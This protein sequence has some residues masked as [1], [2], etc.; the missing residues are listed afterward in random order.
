MNIHYIDSTR[1][2]KSTGSSCAQSGWT[3][4]SFPAVS[5]TA[6][7][8]ARSRPFRL[9][10]EIRHSLPRHLPRH[11]GRCHRSRS[12]IW[13]VSTM[14]MSTEFNR[15]HAA[16]GRRTDY[17]V[18][19]PQAATSKERSE[20]SN[21]GGT[22]RLGRAGHQTLV[23]GFPGRQ[24]ATAPRRS[25]ERH[26]HR[27]EV[28]NHYRDQ[29]RQGRACVSRACPS[30]IWSRWSS[31][32]ITRGSWQASSTPNS[33]PTRVTAIRCSRALSAPRA[34]YHETA[35]PEVREA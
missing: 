29:S 13:P 18:A 27:Y 1:T 34:Q 15:I 26:R 5:A 19:G 14:R 3:A 11:A 35:M 30:T 7:S 23:A 2:L 21:L 32:R 28:N 22:M 24:D 6:A 9:A 4:S 20:A 12:H 16:P 25:V 31:C 17:R 8:R 10:R 33:P